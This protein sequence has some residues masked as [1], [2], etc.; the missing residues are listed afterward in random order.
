M[1]TLYLIISMILMVSSCA[2]SEM[3]KQ[4]KNIEPLIMQDPKVA[5]LTLD[6]IHEAEPLALQAPAEMAQYLLLDTYCKYRTNEKI[7]NDS[8]ISIAEDYFLQHGTHHEKMLSLF[9]HGYVLRKNKQQSE[10]ILKYKAA[11]D[12]G[13]ECNDHFMLG[14][15]YT[16]LVF[17]CGEIMDDDQI[18]FSEKALEHYMIVGREPYILDSE[19]NIG[20]AKLNYNTF[21]EEALEILQKAKDRAIIYNDTLILAKCYKLLAEAEMK[22]GKFDSA[23]YYYQHTIQDLHSQLGC[24]N[25]DLMA[26]VCASLGMRDSALA[27][28]DRAERMAKSKVAS[29][30]HWNFA[31]HVYN[32]LGDSG[33]ANTYYSKQVHD[34]KSN[35]KEKLSNTVAKEQRDYV[36][37]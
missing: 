5:Q 23:Y 3:Q 12:E 4:L 2:D 28:L 30:I 37:Q 32:Q 16:G 31:A 35:F 34:L 17:L 20:M 8:L 1:K 6:S 24:R 27:Y 26:Y 14:Q 33:K 29:R 19:I 18:D 10:S 15:I 36:E 22:M 13:V 7:P 9:L 21:T 25:C 11:L